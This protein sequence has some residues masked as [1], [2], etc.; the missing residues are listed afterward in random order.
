MYDFLFKH[1]QLNASL[2]YNIGTVK[3]K[4]RR[5]TLNSNAYQYT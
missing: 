1:S 4:I 2:S 5:K 3:A